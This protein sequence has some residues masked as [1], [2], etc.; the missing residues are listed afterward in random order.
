MAPFVLLFLRGDVSPARRYVMRRLAAT[1]AALGALL[2]VT[3]EAA[4]PERPMAVRQP[5][6]QSVVRIKAGELPVHTQEPVQG[7]RCRERICT[8]E[9]VE[10]EAVRVPDPKQ[11]AG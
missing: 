2:V 9:P 4:V 10:V 1:V 3:A 5:M 8:P 11:L 6:V 7:A